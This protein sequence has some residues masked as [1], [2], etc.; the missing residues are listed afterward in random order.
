MR[1]VLLIVAILVL[2]LKEARR[3]MIALIQQK[4][5]ADTARSIGVLWWV[6]EFNEGTNPTVS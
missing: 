3:H 4:S 2:L 6:A 5:L 1:E